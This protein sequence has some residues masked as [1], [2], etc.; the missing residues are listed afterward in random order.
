MSPTS[1]DHFVRTL[2]GLK[3]NARIIPRDHG[4]MVLVQL[5]GPKARGQLSLASGN[6]ADKPLMHPNFMEHPDD[7]APLVRAQVPSAYRPV[8]TCRMGTVEDAMSV[9]DAQLRVHGIEGLRVADASIMPNIV[10]GNTSAPSTM[11]GER[12]AAFI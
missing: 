3:G 12:A 1:P 8:G 9:V 5:L 11:I 10:G 7:V 6:P 4:F 2:P